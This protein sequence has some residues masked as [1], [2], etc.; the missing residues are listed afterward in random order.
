MRDG[1]GIDK[2]NVN[3]ERQTPQV[4]EYLDEVATNIYAKYAGAVALH[5]ASDFVDLMKAM[6]DRFDNE[7]NGTN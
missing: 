1:H 3:I 5:A 7:I 4:R 6:T 2:I